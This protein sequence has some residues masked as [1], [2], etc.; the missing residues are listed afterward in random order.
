M[1]DAA[2]FTRV[3]TGIDGLDTVLNGGFIAPRSYAIT[4]DPGTGKTLLGVH[5]LVA[6]D[7]DTSLYVHLEESEDAIRQNASQVELNLDGVVFLNLTPEVDRFADSEDYSIFE[8]SETE[9]GPLRDTITNTVEEVDP[10]RVFIDSLS[11]LQQFTAESSDFRRQ[12]S[13]L[14]KF[15]RLHGATTLFTTQQTPT[16]P[17]DNF[18]YLS[19]GTVALSMSE[20]GRRIRVPK[21]RGSNT[22]SGSHT[23]RIGD[24][25]VEVFPVLRPEAHETEF[26]AESI[27]SGIPGVDK[28]LDGGLTRGTVTILS[29]ASGV[30]KTTLGA[31]LMKAAAGRGERSLIYLFE[32][33][34][35]TFRSRSKAVNIP[36]DEMIDHGT[37]S[38]EP[39]EPLAMSPA[40]FATH[41]RR[42]VEANDARIV[43]I[44]GIDGYRLSL[45][46][47]TEQLDR[48]LHSLCRYLKNMGVT[49]IL[50]DATDAVTGE[51][52]PTR[53]GVSYLGDTLV[54]LRYLEIRG[55]LRKAIGVLKKRTG[56]HERMLREFDITP[57]GIEVG[58][59]LTNLHGILSGTPQLA[60]DA[61]AE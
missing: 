17:D 4:G 39:V 59:P 16:T 19:D 55:E 49:I 27:S 6:D 30:G 58:D 52:Q 46:D 12:L 61:T 22:R 35:R 11:A 34:T 53:S 42:E 51:F 26:P 56:D 1:T 14:F 43:M 29:G 48:E 25:G 23:L 2:S 31:Q 50:V 9:G 21:F 5:F 36:V 44:D 37:L 3:S 40:E 15:F 13:S 18:R 60:D 41:V 28:L 32:E 33:S 47:P 7:A 54:F 45:S 38:V 8:P 57:Y 20:H 10:D 24:D